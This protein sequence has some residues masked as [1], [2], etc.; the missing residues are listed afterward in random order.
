MDVPKFRAS[1]LSLASLVK[2]IEVMHEEVVVEDVEQLSAMKLYSID[3]KQSVVGSRQCRLYI[4]RRYSS[5]VPSK[6]VSRTDVV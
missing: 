6:I 3:Q 2:C 5:S 4:T 1:I